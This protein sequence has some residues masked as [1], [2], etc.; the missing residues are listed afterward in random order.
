[1]KALFDQYAPPEI[2]EQFEFPSREQ[3]DGFAAKL[4]QALNGDSFD[5]LAAYEPQARAALAAL[6]TIPGY[7]D[8]ADWLQERLDLIQ[9]AGEAAHPAPAPGPVPPVLPYYDLWLRRLR[10]RPAP[11][12]AAALMPGL[13]AAF[14]AEGVPPD[15]AWLAE[16][17][18]G[19]NPR[20]RSPAGAR[21][22]FQ[23]MPATAEAAG[24]STF[25]PDERTDPAKSARAAAQ[26]L[27]RLR[28]R[29]GDWPLAL[30]A[31]N[32]GEGRVGRA[33]AARHART[34]AEVAPALPVETRLYVPKVYATIAVRTGDAPPR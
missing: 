22:L 18:S 33:L 25:Q 13:R 14:A 15:L 8:Y 24:L 31:Y 2:Q 30:A 4:Q 11:A 9:A 7:E 20:A 19:L 17:E 28:R 29:F 26:L 21:G 12:G 1:G 23:L 6:R 27:S 32:A 10:D 16:V 5:D 3:W 34:F